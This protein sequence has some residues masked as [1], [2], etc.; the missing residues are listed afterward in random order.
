M[1]VIICGGG[2]IGA[3][4]AYFC[5]KRGAEVVVVERHRVAGAASGKSGGF[6][7]L[8]WNRGTRLDRLARRSFDLHAELAEEL[9]DA[10]GRDWG[11]YRRLATFMGH[12]DGNAPATIT[13]QI[14]TTETTAVVE[15]R[16]FTTGLLDAA[17]RLGAG[18]TDGTVEGLTRTGDRVTGVRLSSGEIIAGDAVVIAMGP[19]S[20]MASGWLALPAVYGVKGHSLVFATGDRTPKDA[21]FLEVQNR[22][23]RQNEVLTPEIFPRANG[24][25]WACA[26]SSTQG[27][28]ID[29]AEVGPDDGAHERLEALCRAVVPALATAEVV[30][31]QACFRP[32]TEDGLPFMGALPG[33][34]GAYIATGHSVWGMLNAPASGEAMAELVLDGAARTVDLRPFRPDRLRPLDPKAVSGCFAR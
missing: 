2:A 18:L 14:G 28:P 32:L 15:P 16:A 27:L 8:D 13:G 31:R 11:L 22:R 5:S 10:L 12:S 26:I 9:S 33:A 34:P 30:A 24:T 20:I 3:A 4:T 21:W 6:L 19:W 17:R 1:R 29:P 25:V 7:A 23:G